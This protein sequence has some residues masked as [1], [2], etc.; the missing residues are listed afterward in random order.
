[1]PLRLREDL[2]RQLVRGS[3]GI[4][5]ARAVT[6][7]RA[8]DRLETG[9]FQEA[10]M[11]RVSSVVL[12]QHVADQA[13]WPRIRGL[14]QTLPRF[15]QTH[16]A[17]ALA[18]LFARIYPRLTPDTDPVEYGRQKRNFDRRFA[19]GRQ[20]EQLEGSFGVGILILVPAEF[21]E[22]WWHQG[23]GASLREVFVKHLRAARPQLP[24]MRRR[25]QAHYDHLTIRVGLEGFPHS[26]E[27]F[28]RDLRGPLGVDAFPPSSQLRW[29]EEVSEDPVTPPTVRASR[30]ARPGGR[31]GTAVGESPGSSLSC[32]LS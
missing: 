26:R 13:H 10:V 17:H 8:L 7:Y 22:S 31:S 6:I 14:R 29:N 28:E 5:T 25:A 1:M 11:H 3:K 24:G 32:T 30:C 19:V 21:P 9:R 20:W 4:G 15:G 18:N 16:M 12:A 27:H 2:V 23:V